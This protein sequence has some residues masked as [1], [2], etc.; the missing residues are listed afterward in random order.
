MYNAPTRLP[1]YDMMLAASY[2][3]SDIDTT[4]PTAW[5]DPTA[6]RW[7]VVWT[8][9]VNEPEAEGAP[10]S[11]PLYVAVSAGPNPLEEWTV[12]VLELR[13]STAPGLPFC[14]GVPSTWFLADYPQV[15]GAVQ[16][17]GPPGALHN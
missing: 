4:D 14:R 5:F 8:S 9:F 6:S 11:A 17:R 10:D 16:S 15:C 2:N 7:V 1:I 12:W 13:P 3:A